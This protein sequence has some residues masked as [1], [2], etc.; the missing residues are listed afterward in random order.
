MT[1]LDKADDLLPEDALDGSAA[2]IREAIK[3]IQ[4][5][6]ENLSELMAYR[7]MIGVD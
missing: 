1:A 5:A 7:K 6:A 3:H 4:N 2:D